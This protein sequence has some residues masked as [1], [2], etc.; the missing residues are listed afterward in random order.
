MQN[1][2]IKRDVVADGDVA[3]APHSSST[4]V[5]SAKPPRSAPRR[6]APGNAAPVESDWATDDWSDDVDDQAVTST[7]NERPGALADTRPQAPS[8]ADTLPQ[9]PSLADTLPQATSLVDTTPDEPSLADT[10]PQTPSFGVK[11]PAV[12]SPTSSSPSASSPSA[13]SPTASSPQSASAPSASS[14]SASAPMNAKQ[15]RAARRLAAAQAAAAAAAGESPD[16]AP[17]GDTETQADPFAAVPAPLRRALEQ[18]GFAALTEVQTA[19]LAADLPGRNLRISSQTGSGKTVALGMVLARDMLETGSAERVGPEALVITPTRELA[20]QVA[21]ELAWLFGDVRGVDVVSVTGG[22]EVWKDRKPLARK[23]RIVVGTPGRLNDHINTGTL[24]TDSIR[25]VVLDEADQMLDMGFRDELD[26]IVGALPEERRSHLVSATFPP[27]VKQLADRFQKNPLHVAG[28][29]LGQANQDIEHIAHLVRPRE[30]Y[31]ALVNVLL[32]SQGERTLIFV[33]RRIDAQELSE[34][35]A[36]DGFPALH[37][38]GDLAQAQRTR[39]LNAFKAGVIDT[40]ICTD[41]AARGLDVPDIVRV[42]HMG[43]SNDPDVYIHR[44]GRTGRAGRKGQSVLIVP[45]SAER[46]V[47]RLLGIAR[48]SVQWRPTPTA[49]RVLKSRTKA[50]RVRMHELLQ[51]GV[52]VAPGELEYA[53]TLLAERDPAQLVAALLKLSEKPLPREPFALSSV[54]SKPTRPGESFGGRPSPAPRG[55]GSFQAFFINWGETS[56]ANPSR[57][58]AHICRRGGI[59]GQAVGAV[60][61]EA[62][63][64]VFEVASD[65]AAAFEEAMRK[66]DPREPGLRVERFRGAIPDAAPRARRDD[67]SGPAPFRKPRFGPGGRVNPRDGGPETFE[68]GKPFKRKRSFQRHH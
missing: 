65:V 34:M 32:M 4:P 54:T 18:R 1:D 50:A 10:I 25:H 3:S 9:A 51:E 21:E 59:S 67:R 66:P 58:I 45:S 46:R 26:A 7:T 6:S 36:G 12:S 22:T 33:E 23:P 55:S 5:A 61:I 39:T 62:R 29:Q 35:L 56:G 2:L 47:Q 16:G 60:R 28:T 30:S 20:T 17:E 11:P 40:L 52:P 63:T 31:A 41:V 15:K 37:L 8:L 27:A 43:L 24:V 48:V 38:S 64:S 13:S 68:A 42:I 44:S 49:D 57:V 19:V 14:P 53:Q